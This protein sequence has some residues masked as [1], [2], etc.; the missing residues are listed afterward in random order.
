MLEGL[1]VV[2]DQLLEMSQA[3]LASPSIPSVDLF[4]PSL[5]FRRLADF[6]VLLGDSALPLVVGWSGVLSDFRESVAPHG[7]VFRCSRPSE[8]FRADEASV[9]VARI[10]LFVL[11]A[12]TLRSPV[13]DIAR[14]SAEEVLVALPFFRTDASGDFLATDVAVHAIILPL[15][16]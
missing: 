5:V 2:G 7:A 8:V 14:S 9:S 3:E 10:P 13:D 1:D 12:R 11:R 15:P 4:P 6:F 16:S